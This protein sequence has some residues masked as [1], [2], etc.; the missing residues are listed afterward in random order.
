VKLE[1]NAKAGWQ[2]T[3]ALVEAGTSY[4]YQT[5]GKWQF[6]PTGEVD[7]DGSSGGQGRLVGVIFDDFKLGEPF[8]LGVNGEFN[9]YSDGQLYVRCQDDWTSLSDNGG[10]IE[11]QLNRVKTKK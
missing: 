1:V 9:A 10:S 8:E 3:K 11:L 6:E 5:S 2:A 4:R 7:A